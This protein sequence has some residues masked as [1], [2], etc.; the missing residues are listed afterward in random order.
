[1]SGY[2][3]SFLTREAFGQFFR[4]GIVGSFNTVVD[5]ALLNFFFLVLGWSAFWSVTWALA[6]ATG[7]SYALNRRWTF[8]L[9][10]FFGSAKETAGFFAVSLLAWGITVAAV[11]V[12]EAWLGSL[13][14]LELNA[15]KIVAIGVILPLKFA[16]Y[17]DLV[18]RRSLSRVRDAVERGS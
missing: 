18:F 12:A 7:V 8:R 16:G 5:F 6:I 2:L 11:E 1:M 14:V 15:A 13:G 10:S 9:P 3:R 17:R 4:L